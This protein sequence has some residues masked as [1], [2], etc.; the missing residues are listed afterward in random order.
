LT[1]P[2]HH[3]TG[4]TL[5]GP[6]SLTVR[7]QAELIGEAINRPVRVEPQSLDDYR[8]TLSRWSPEIVAARIRRIAALVGHPAPITDTVR[9]VT[10]RPA[11]TFAD[12]AAD[13]A[14]DF[15]AKAA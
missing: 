1:E 14:S 11:R 8:R 7:C 9:E 10:G 6:K 2:E 13:H 12:W 5:T 3:G 4:Y 15:V